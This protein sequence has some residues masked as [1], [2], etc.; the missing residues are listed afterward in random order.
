[1]TAATAL[2]AT[3]APEKH[4]G[5]ALGTLQMAV[6]LGASVGPLLGGLVADA[7]GY[8]AAFF[9]TSGL[10]LTAA[11]EVLVFV[12]EPLQPVETLNNRTS[13]GDREATLRR[14]IWNNLSPVL[15]SAPLLGVFAVRML[16]RLGAGLMGPTLPLFVETI[17]PPHA[18]VATLT[19]LITGAG[20][21]GGAAGSLGLGK[22]SDRVGYRRTVASCA[23]VC[24]LCYAAQSMVE[25][26]IW[27]ISLQAT[28]GLAM[29][30][31]LASVGAL[32]AN[33]APKGRAGIVYGVEGS[34]SSVASAIGPVTG[35]VL[36]AA[37]GLRAPF[38]GSAA[39]FAVG[40]VVAFRLFPKG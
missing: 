7:L 38:L 30:G 33:L 2:V 21:L 5:Y 37:L 40:V 35:S 25:R 19:G 6:Y 26:S 32:L 23:L 17:A 20:A 15:A 34:I 27:L 14:R 13:G 10:L 36:A 12:R 29:G 8:R 31:M 11:L 4:A 28:A 39:V 3:S 24:G 1:V 9:V 16:I 22:L 18:R